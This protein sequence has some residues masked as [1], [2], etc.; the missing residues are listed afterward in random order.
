MK[1][2]L[3]CLLNLIVAYSLVAFAGCNGDA[4]NLPDTSLSDSAK[5]EEFTVII[6]V[7]ESYF[8]SVS[9]NVVENVAKN[10]PIS[11]IGNKILIGDTEI[12]ASPNAETEDYVYIFEKWSFPEKVVGDLT[13]TAHFKRSEK[14]APVKYVVTVENG[15]GGGEYEEGEEVTVTPTIP[16][17]KVFVKWISDGED[18]STDNPFV[19]NV[20]GNTVL[21]AVFKDWDKR[22]DAIEITAANQWFN[23]ETGLENFSSSDKALVFDYKAIDREVNKGDEFWFTLWKAEWQPPRLS[24]II[25]IDVAKNTS[26]VGGVQALEDGWYHVVIPAKKI[27]INTTE[28]AGG[29]ETIGSFVFTLVDHAILID[30]VGFID[31]D[32]HDDAIEINTGNQWFNFESG[33]E[34]FA[35]SDKALVF[36]YKAIDRETNDGDEFR[37]TLW[38]TDWSPIRRT[39]LISVDVVNNTVSVG[40]VTEL[41]NGW[42]RVSIPA[43]ELPINTEEGATGEESIGSFIFNDVSHA[44]YID[45]AGFEKIS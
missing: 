1:K 23:I 21:T 8:G 45:E 38:G 31:P 16:S 6:S 42:Y 10:T 36:D 27:S 39:D 19:F 14:V 4:N 28:G 41:G 3:F 12:T 9:R 37:F 17:G 24:E 40:S 43:S 2:I 7:N 15:T 30:E 33:L 22:D 18:V 26:T 35:S 25:V 32:I 13:V 44:V 20:S 5:P 29:N 11:A 34:N